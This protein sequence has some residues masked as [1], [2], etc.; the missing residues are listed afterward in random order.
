MYHTANL[1]RPSLKLVLGLKPKS[2]SN[3]DVSAQ[4]D[5]LIDRNDGV[6]NLCEMKFADSEYA[7]DSTEES[8]LRNRRSAFRLDTETKKSVHITLVTTYGLRKNSHSGIVQSV[9]T[10][11]DLFF[12]DISDYKVFKIFYS[13]IPRGYLTFFTTC[14][15]GITI[16]VVFPSHINLGAKLLIIICYMKR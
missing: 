6:I 5:L 4:I 1:R 14:P 11:N 15:R 9:V 16:T 8:K 2:F 3:A 13:F 7:L 10:L 12:V